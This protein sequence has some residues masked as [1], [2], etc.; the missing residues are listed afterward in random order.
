MSHLNILHEWGVIFLF[1]VLW[2]FRFKNVLDWNP[3][4]ESYE[5]NFSNFNK[6]DK[7]EM[8]TSSAKHHEE[9]LRK[10]RSRS[11]TEDKSDKNPRSK[12]VPETKLTANN[13]ITR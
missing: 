6:V 9:I 1:Q 10:S 3:K 7:V 4:L 11:K 12:S 5:I 13:H 2:G 8:S